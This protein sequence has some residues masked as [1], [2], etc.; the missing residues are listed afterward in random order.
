MHH[1][2]SLDKF[3]EI[4]HCCIVFCAYLSV[5]NTALMNLIFILIH[6]TVPAIFEVNLHSE[7]SLSSF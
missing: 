2:P 3:L 4:I 1:K 5:T 6:F 7:K